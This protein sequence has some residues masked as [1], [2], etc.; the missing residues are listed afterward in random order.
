MLKKM[1][2][3]GAALVMLGVGCNNPTQLVS[4]EEFFA[5][6]QAGGATT[7]VYPRRCNPKANVQYIEEVTGNYNEKLSFI[8]LDTP[9]PTAP[10][11]SSVTVTGEAR[12]WYFEAS[13]PVTVETESGVVLGTGVAQAQGDWMTD[14]FVPFEV[15]VEFPPQTAFTRGYLVFHKDNPSGLPEHDDSMR[16]PITFGN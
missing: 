14:Q 16:V 2:I 10:I 15:T 1:L 8:R 9:W 7:M 4:D 12:T 11:K 6:Q 13:F 3:T 5:C